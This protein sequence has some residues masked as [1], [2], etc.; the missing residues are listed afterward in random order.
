MW[1]FC[2]I[3]FISLTLQNAHAFLLDL[4][5]GILQGSFDH[6]GEQTN[7][8]SANSLGFYSNLS[9]SDSNLGLNIGWYILSISNKETYPPTLS[10]TLTS[11]DMGPAIRWQIDRGK[12]FSLTL[13]YGII[14]KGNFNDGVTDES[15]TGESYLLK[16]AIEPEVADR[17]FIGVG[18]NYYVASYKTRVVSSI[19]SDAGYKNTMI[20]PSLSFSYRY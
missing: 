5:S 20:F 14:C 13:A 10:Q 19:Q 18:I 7:S 8:K 4:S 1:K 17:Y 12:K 3:F 11:S 16:F 15:L 2:A 6:S 9:N